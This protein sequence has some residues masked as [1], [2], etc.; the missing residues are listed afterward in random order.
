MS[1]A[2]S[3]D[4]PLA[5]AGPA[6][7]A[8]RKLVDRILGDVRASKE[9]ADLLI[10]YAEPTVQYLAAAG[11]ARRALATRWGAALEPSLDGLSRGDRVDALDAQVALWKF[12]DGLESLAPGRREQV[13]RDIG[14]LVSATTD[15]YERQAVVPSAAHVL[16]A[17]GLIDESDALL[18]A[19]LGRAVSPYYHMLGLASNA[20]KRNDSK[21]A[22]YW[23]EQAWRKSEGP[24]TRI[25]WGTGFVRQLVALAP[26]EIAKVQSSAGA[27]IAQLDAKDETFYE[28]NQRSLQRMA[29][30]LLDWQGSDPAR[31]KA[32]NHLKTQLART[33]A[34]VPVRE[35]GRANC[36]AVFSGNA[37]A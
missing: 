5:T 36:D 29:R 12:I 9:L 33:C 22:L 20:K 10:G 23:Y 30:K 25:Q 1:A 13:A 17:A 16:T 28:R 27:V 11:E 32:V 37:P 34:K 2:E 26:S 24:A 18:K 14:R 21:T 3:D 15:R 19:E 35:P 8:G 7:D 31:Q 4:K 6:A